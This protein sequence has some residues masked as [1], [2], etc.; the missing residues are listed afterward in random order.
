[1][2]SEKDLELLDQYLGSRLNAQ[3]KAAF[4]KQLETDADLK[5]EFT[6]QQKVVDGVRKARVSELKKLLN[7]IPVSSI[8]SEGTSL[9]SKVGLFVLGTALV[10]TA[11]YF[12]LNQE[13][14]SITQ[15]SGTETV[16]AREPAI[17][18]AVTGEEPPK[19]E[20]VESKPEEPQKT[21]STKTPAK[22][23]VVEKSKEEPVAPSPLDVFDPTEESAKTDGVESDGNS[24]KESKTP[25]IL[26]E[27]VTD[28]K[29]TFHYQFK[30]NKLYLYGAFEKNLYEIME[31][32]SD[33]KM[34]MFLFYKDNY[35]LLNEEDER[36]RAL[37]PIKD[38]TLLQ[39]LK[40][41][42]KD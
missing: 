34:T 13:D 9:L 3:D 32:F 7:D 2:A 8:P 23:P 29:Y 19:E 1:M 21:K 36:V 12:Y 26:V 42:R 10:G 31:F 37:A 28:K 14:K 5:N 16:T 24:G 17:T 6:F 38:T 4:E 35:F 40:D 25:S 39:K 41:Y 30:D 18:E 20:L 33:N 11:L 22:A 27:T 15:P